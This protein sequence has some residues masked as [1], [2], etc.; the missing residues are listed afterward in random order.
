MK[1]TL[2]TIGSIATTAIPAVVVVS[3]GEEVEFHKTIRLHVDTSLTKQ[4]NSENINREYD[5]SGYKQGDSV[6]YEVKFKDGHVF[7]V[8]AFKMSAILN[9]KA[10]QAQSGTDRFIE[11]MALGFASFVLSQDEI[12]EIIQSMPAVDMFN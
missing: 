12:L 8:T 7:D 5:R 1:K 2:L 3:C 9:Y 10:S 4:K 11:N 6:I